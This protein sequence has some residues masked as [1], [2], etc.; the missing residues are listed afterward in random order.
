MADIGIRE[1]VEV[2][3]ELRWSWDHGRD[4]LWAEI[5]ADLWMS[6]TNGAHVPSWDF[7][8]A[9]ALWTRA[10]GRERGR[11]AL[12]TDLGQFLAANIDLQAI[13]RHIASDRLRG[14]A[15]PARRQPPPSRFFDGA[16]TSSLAGAAPH[17]KR[18]G[19]CRAEGSRR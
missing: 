5:D 7:R 8:E 14:F 19:P 9:D 6:F 13:S 15:E 18:L 17:R 12:E 10:C 11:G 2:A 16:T 3:P 4:E 1:L